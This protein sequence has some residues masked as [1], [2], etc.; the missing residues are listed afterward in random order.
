[1]LQDLES[2]CYDKPSSI[3]IGKESLIDSSEITDIPTLIA[4]LRED[5][6]LLARA[7]CGRTHFN[8]TKFKINNLG[9]YSVFKM[10]P[11][12]PYIDAPAEYVIILG[13]ERIE[14]TTNVFFIEAKESELDSTGA[15][16]EY[17][18]IAESSDIYTVSFAV[19]KKRLVDLYSSSRV[20]KFVNQL[21]EISFPAITGEE[22]AMCNKLGQEIFDTFKTAND[23]DS[24]AGRA[25]LIAVLSKVNGIGRDGAARCAEIKKAWY[26][27]G[28]DNVFWV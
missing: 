26:G 16:K 13:A 12:S 3:V 10:N 5:G 14:Q 6:S 27:V 4:R 21:A 24:D 20:I 28:D 23:E 17:T 18:P 7:C 1:M 11:G 22:K 25:A 19:F 2:F 9:S 8:Y 15:F